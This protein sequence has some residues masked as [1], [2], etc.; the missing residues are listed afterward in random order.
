MWCL[1]RVVILFGSLFSAQRSGGDVP[2]NS[3]IEFVFIMVA[4]LL[5]VGVLTWFLRDESVT[6][7]FLELLLFCPLFPRRACA[8]WLFVSNIVII[9]GM[10]WLYIGI[11]NKEKLM[12]D[13]TIIVIGLL[14]VLGVTV[15]YLAKRRQP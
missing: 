5:L 14:S 10:M 3:L 2:I 4:I 8:M 15:V 13:V 6:A 11:I 1:L 7:S 9:T 12:I